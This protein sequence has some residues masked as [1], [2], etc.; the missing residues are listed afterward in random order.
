[1][2]PAGLKCPRH[3][4][5]PEG[6]PDSRNLSGVIS[7]PPQPRIHHGPGPPSGPDRRPLPPQGPSTGLDDV[8]EELD[9]CL[10]RKAP[11]PQ[12]PPTPGAGATSANQGGPSAK[13]TLMSGPAFSFDQLSLWVIVASSSG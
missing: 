11:R 8:L 2:T 6:C 5:T 1:M 4:P 12:L 3:P 9:L 7:R 10:L 13:D